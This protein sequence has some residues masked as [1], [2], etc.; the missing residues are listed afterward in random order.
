MVHLEYCIQIGSGRLPNQQQ[1]QQCVGWEKG[2]AGRPEA[3]EL[4]EGNKALV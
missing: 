4:G 3:R 2:K 1:W